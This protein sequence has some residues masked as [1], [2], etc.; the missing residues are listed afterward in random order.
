MESKTDYREEAKKLIKR[1]ISVFPLKP[2]GS[3]VPKIR[4][5]D[6]QNRFMTEFEIEQHCKNCG[7]LGAV[8]GSF[9]KL[10]CFDF[11]LDK[12]L[13]TDDYWTEFCK[14]IP[15]ELLKKFRVNRTRSGGKHVWFRVT[16]YSYPSTKITHR[17]LTLEE[18]NKKVQNYISEKEGTENFSPEGF[19]RKILNKPVECVVE[20]R[21]EGGF[22]VIMHENYVQ[23][24]GKKIHEISYE[25]Y[26]ILELALYNLD[27][28]FVPFK[29][30][31]GNVSKYAIIS[32]YN[33]NVEFDDVI[34]MI[35][36]TGLYSLN[37]FDRVGNALLKR[38]GSNNPYSS[39]VFLDTKLI[40]DFG[41]SSI[42]TDG[43]DVHSPYELLL[44]INNEMSEEDILRN[45]EEIYG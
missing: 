31:S 43:K 38:E 32:K 45:L 16:N 19:Y 41:M 5:K 30:Y 1:G 25:E 39:K 29:P 42:F 26:K 24:Y 21:F 11:D 10:V 7:G 4:W 13:E 9:S 14:Q 44:E 35:C 40:K 34:N 18:I 37:G 17:L 27:C 15:K 3:K 36:E 12:Q 8:C 23:E 28:G 2:D 33:D 22:G 20:T 6:F